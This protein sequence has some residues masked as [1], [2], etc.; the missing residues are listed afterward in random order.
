MNDTGAARTS[1]LMGPIGSADGTVPLGAAAGRLPL[2][3]EVGRPH[4]PVLDSVR[5]IAIGG[6]L[7]VHAGVP[8]FKAGWLGVDLFFALSGFLIT[9]LLLQ[10]KEASGDIR[11][12]KFW[13]RRF[14][15]L[16]PAYYLYAAGVTL[17]FWLW[18]GSV[19]HEHGG[20]SPLEYTL[21]LWFYLMNYPPL[22]GIW[23][24]QE[25]TVH[26]WSLALEEQ[27]YLLWPLA[28]AALLRRP[29][30]LLPFAWCLFAAVLAYFLF[31]AS[32]FERTV[33]L[34][35][36]GFSLFLASALALTL[37]C[38]QRAGRGL[39]AWLP[40][41]ARLLPPV[42][43]VSALVLAVSW[44]GWLDEP[45]VRLFF[46]PGTVALYVLLVAS[47]WYRPLEDGPWKTLLTWPPLVYVGRISYGIYLYHQAARLFIWHTTAE[48]LA[49]WPAVAA[50]GL[51][52]GLY[53]LL[54]VAVASLSFE[55]IERSFLKLGNRFR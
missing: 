25:S 10:E 52:L 27:Y 15:R 51:R 22:G 26:L 5:A 12:G 29:R 42:A 50:Y 55:M 8:G 6:V 49:G 9:T 38:R 1:S 21:A 32:D 14:L 40:A 16:M 23:N 43:G 17:A 44:L 7:T 48:L 39:P 11:L 28:L 37:F 2:R 46:L 34:Y 41:P 31:F 53:L 19:R 13:A 4:R 33:R 45:L 36:R 35:G 54:A 18:P 20:W 24:G 3:E 30:W 47:L